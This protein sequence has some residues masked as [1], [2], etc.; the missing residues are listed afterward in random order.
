MRQ[1]LQAAVAEHIRE[2]LPIYILTT[3]LFTAGVAAGA[4]FVRLLPES[5]VYELNQYFFS[6]VDFLLAGKP[7]NQTLILQKALLYNGIFIALLWFFGNL[8]F[9]FVPVLA[10]LFYR[11]F[12]IGFTVGFLA[13]HNFM[14]GI[15][16][17]LGAILPQNLV[18]VPVSILAAVCAVIFSFMLLKRRMTGKAFPY[19]LWFVQFSLLMLLGMVLLAAGGLIESFITPVFMRAIVT[20]L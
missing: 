19:R 20:T 9:G 4:V 6:F 5:Q 3:F 10:L 7:V 1:S 17:A 12:A 16:F 13:Q 11:G 2:Q 14:H 15:I 8:F 18:Y